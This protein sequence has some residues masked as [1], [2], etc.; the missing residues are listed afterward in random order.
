MKKMIFVVTALVM[1]LLSFSCSKEEPVSVYSRNIVVSDAPSITSFTADL[2]ATINGVDKAEFALAKKGVIYCMKSDNAES[3]FKAWKEG[4]DDS[5]CIVCDKVE[6]S[7]ETVQCLL[8]GLSD[9]TEYSFCIFLLK[10][11]GT[12]E[13]SHVSQFRTQ[14]FNPELKVLSMKAVECFVAFATGNINMN[15][16]DAPFCEIG[17]LLS[18]QQDCSIESSKVFRADESA[19]DNYKV[20]I[21]DLE[22]DH[23]YYCRPYIKYPVSKG[24]YA[25]LY[26]PETEF[27]TKNFNDVAVDL[28]LPSGNLWA[29]YNVG[30]AKPQEYGNYYAWG[31]VEPKSTYSWSNYKLRNE[32]FT[33]D[34]SL[35]I[36]SHK[37]LD[38]KNDA[39]NYNWGGDW[40]RFTDEDW[41]ELR[42]NCD[43]YPGVLEDVGGFY[44]RSRIN[45]DSIFFPA[46]G[47]K[48]DYELLSAGTHCYMLSG[49]YRIVE[50]NYKIGSYYYLDAN[51]EDILNEKVRWSSGVVVRAVYPPS[52]ERLATMDIRMVKD[53]KTVLVDGSTALNAVVKKNDEIIKQSVK[54]SSDNPSVATVDKNGVVTGVS[55]GTAH[56]TASIK[57]LSAQ[58]TVTVVDDTSVEPEYVDLGL[59]VK[60]ATFNV[61]ALEPEDYGS[62]YAWGEINTKTYYSWENYRFRIEGDSYDNVKLNKYNQNS[63]Y[64]PVDDNTT[65]D[66]EDDVA[67]VRWGGTWRLPTKIE[68]D[69]LRDNCTWTWY[70]S[71]NSEFNGVAGYKINSNK[72]GCTDRFIFLPSAGYRNGSS[73]GDYWSSS[74]TDDWDS[75]LAFG[76]WFT[77][78][79]ISYGYNFRCSVMAVRPVCP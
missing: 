26:G 20:R 56:I 77:T 5:G 8:S 47:L 17:V 48:N 52:E 28:G 44:L 11:D 2:S 18:G 46:S 37:Q 68:Q 16:K 50:G 43:F 53:N 30:A 63:N 4:S 6:I 34:N 23:C 64:G 71:G 38:L 62:Y 10:R 14:P 57:S 76:L 35:N 72:P 58:C 22:S 21:A 54:W 1:S 69:E 78:D 33:T 3:A 12:R 19:F 60:W 59:S 70:D 41:N 31:E 42:S 39:A 49:S 13:I 75:R 32:S 45:G 15:V 51:N 40:Y 74:L 73:Y 36:L 25:Y 7:G 79:Y 9:D 29:S 24:N 61:G 55:I 27:S 67:H 65:L 66:P